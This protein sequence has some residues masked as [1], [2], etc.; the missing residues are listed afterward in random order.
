LKRV[1][2]PL[3]KLKMQHILTNRVL[4]ILAG[5][6]VLADCATLAEEFARKATELK[7][8]REVVTGTRFQ[9]V[10]YSNTGHL[11]KTLHI[12][13]DGDGTPWIAGR[14]SDDP[15]PLNP[16]VLNLMALDKAPAVY[17]GRPCYHGVTTIGACS[18]R[19]WLKDRYSEEV[20]GSLSTVI[21]QLLEKGNY[22]KIVWFGHSGGGALAVLLAARFPQTTAVVTVAANLDLAAW[23]TYTG[24][25]DL[26]GSLNPAR[27]PAFS[28]SV[29]Q[30][31]Y[32]GGKD[33][34]VPP[35]LMAKAAAHLGSE[36]IV[37]DS[38]D[39]ICCWERL[40][41]TVLD[42]LSN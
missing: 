14:P 37:I 34:I 21:K 35:A 22:E 24:H 32:A 17:V 8:N 15:T 4:I 3:S 9:H 38:Y 25:N 13:L 11:S 27:L 6:C 5:V 19:F 39:H 20:V 16:M 10:I 36:L 12:Y 29:R 33:R 41:P 1:S 18:S 2:Q 40:W 28:R 31:H 23:A 7:L 30:R 26:S 42:E